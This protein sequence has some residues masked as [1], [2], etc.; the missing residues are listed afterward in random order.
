MIVSVGHTD[1]TYAQV[2]EAVRAGRPSATHVFN[3]MAPLHQR[4][5]GVVGAVLDLPEVSCELIC[6]GVHVDPGR[7]CAW[8]GGEGG[9]GR[10]VGDDA[11]AAAGMPDGEYRLGGR[12]VSVRE[13]RAVL[14][15]GESI[16]GSHADDGGRCA[17]RSAVSGSLGGG[18]AIMAST[19]SARML[20]L[21]DRK[22]AIRAG[23]DADLVVLDE[24]LAVRATMVAG[25]WLLGRPETI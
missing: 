9:A 8:F 2:R 17:E 10:E 7:R 16:A 3:A 18:G 11:M 19:N 4:A 5:P 12:P 6:D 25:E 1:A 22:G 21:G 14:K 13:G 24:N 15:G 23:F 20:G